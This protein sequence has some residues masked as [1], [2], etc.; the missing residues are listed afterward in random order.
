MFKELLEQIKYHD[1]IILLRHIFPDYDAIGS[2]MGLASFIQDNF[3]DKKVLIGGKLPLEYETIGKSDR[4][5]A[6]DFKG[7][8][9]IITDTA[10][11]A[12]I[13][14]ENQDFLKS[15]SMVFK[16]D[17]HINEEHYGDFEIV[18]PTYPATCELLTKLFAE[19]KLIFSRLTAFCLFH[20]LVTDTGRFMYRSVSARTFEMAAILLKNGA[21]FK[22]AYE[23]IYQIDAKLMYLKGYILSNF[24]ITENQVAYIVITQAILQKFQIDNPHQ[25]ALWV[26]ILGELK[27]AKMW[28]FFVETSD[29]IRVEFR[30]NSISVREMAVQ[31]NGGGHQTAAGARLKTLN[32]CQKV[33]EFCDLMVKKSLL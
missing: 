17:H 6:R 32:E 14:V 1:T 27:A 24:K 20:G 4:L 26:N 15:A 23:N 13:D 31:F 33:V 21:D 12:R 30:S 16:I 18:D 25:V 29:H 28:L 2:Q 22:K 8:L 3:T 19:S 5:S 10:T 9:V 11:K 7:A